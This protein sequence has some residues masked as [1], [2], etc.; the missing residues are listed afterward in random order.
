MLRWMQ[1]MYF[2]EP[3]PFHTS[4]MDIQRKE[5]ALGLPLVALIL[6]LGIY[7]APILNEI[8]P[9]AKKINVIAHLEKF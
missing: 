7:P 2:E 1:K 8:K 5:F 3:S 9:A 6:W 4:W